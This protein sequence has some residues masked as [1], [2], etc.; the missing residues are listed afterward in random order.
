MVLFHTGLAIGG[1]TSIADCK[2]CPCFRNVTN[3]YLRHDK[4]ETAMTPPGGRCFTKCTP[5]TII[6]GV[7]PLLQTSPFLEF[8][9][10]LKRAPESIPSCQRRTLMAKNDAG[11]LMDAWE[12]HG[13]GR[14]STSLVPPH[15]LLCSRTNGDEVPRGGASFPA[16]FLYVDD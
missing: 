4:A 10:R 1:A 7:S 16:S 11:T 2:Y 6:A 5:A 8:S 15:S 3:C 13:N 14:A 9:D 12:P